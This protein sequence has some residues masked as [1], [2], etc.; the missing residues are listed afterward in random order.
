M[1]GM[2]S[3][4]DKVKEICDVLRH[5]T[6]EPAKRQAEHILSDASEEAQRIVAEAEAQ[7]NRILHEARAEI[8]RLRSAAESSLKQAAQQ[9]VETL[10]YDIERK[11]F[12]PQ[13]AKII[14]QPL[15]DPK[16]LAKLIEAVLQSLEKEGVDGDLSVY[17]SSAVNPR[18]V[19][20]L[21]TQSIL[22]RLKEKSVL[23]SSMG[24]GISVKLHKEDMTIDISDSAI[25]DMLMQ[26]IRKD[27]R[28]L[29]F[30]SNEKG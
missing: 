14:D 4:K 3:G 24:G 6:L 8:E 7:A 16:V 22:Q 12:Q 10:K 5:E 11:L 30:G 20:E 19:N 29:F 1:K 27:F 18:A 21:V 28:E 13:I 9:S 2:Q 25:K 23:I 26:F 15:Q 17:V